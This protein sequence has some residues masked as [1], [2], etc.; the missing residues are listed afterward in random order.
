MAKIPTYT[1]QFSGD[2][3][4]SVSDALDYA[5]EHGRLPYDL[6][7]DED[8]ND[9]GLMPDHAKRQDLA[10]RLAAQGLR[11]ED[12]GSGYAVVEG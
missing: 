5:L 2:D 6:F 12:D 1:D 3:R 8:G 10:D 9:G 11:L 4:V 7:Q